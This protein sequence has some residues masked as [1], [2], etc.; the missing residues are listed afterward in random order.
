MRLAKMKA[1]ST[2]P[3]KLLVSRLG[4]GKRTREGA[5]V[6]PAAAAGSVEVRASRASSR[7]TALM[8]GTWK[9]VV[10]SWKV[11]LKYLVCGGEGGEEQGGRGHQGEVGH[12]LVGGWMGGRGDRRER[13]GRTRW[14]G[15]VA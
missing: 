8:R 6:S 3:R 5:Q 13:K 14:D 15:S 1:A 2:L 4:W 9:K 10:G 7:P 12:V 11:P